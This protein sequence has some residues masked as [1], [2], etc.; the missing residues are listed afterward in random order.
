VLILDNDER[1]SRIIKRGNMNEEEILVNNNP[2]IS[3]RINAF[4]IKLGCIPLYIKNE[5]SPEDILN[6][7]MS[8]IEL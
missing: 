7:I 5:D 6:M 1:I 3:D 8:H 4:Y 2:I